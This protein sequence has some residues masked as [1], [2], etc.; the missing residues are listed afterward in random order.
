MS[1]L[2]K[3][4]A[5]GNWLTSRKAQHQAELFSLSINRDAPVDSIRIKAGHIESLTH[6]L[7]AFTDLYN[8]DLG[9]FMTE[10]LGQKPDDDD[11]DKESKAD[12][13]TED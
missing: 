5:F 3:M 8:G 4:M 11:E 13:R 6:V 7:E 12:G 10:Y 2:D 1:E 9:K